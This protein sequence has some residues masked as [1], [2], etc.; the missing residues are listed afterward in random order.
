MMRQ[1][2]GSIDARMVRVPCADPI[3]SNRAIA[4]LSK[5]L[6]EIAIEKTPRGIARQQQDRPA[7]G[8]ALIDVGHAPSVDR[9][10]MLMPWEERLEKRR[11]GR[12]PCVLYS[13]AVKAFQ[14]ILHRIP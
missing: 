1:S 7:G 13:D 8:I 9:N 5:G 10:L 3:R 11:F 14:N 12:H 2:Q 6:D 4:G